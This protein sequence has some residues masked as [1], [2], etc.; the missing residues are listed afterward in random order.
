M[1]VFAHT[2]VSAAKKSVKQRGT[3]E[4]SMMLVVKWPIDDRIL[5]RCSTDI[6]FDPKYGMLFAITYC[7]LLILPSEVGLWSTR[8]TISRSRIHSLLGPTDC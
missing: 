5:E 8:N 7:F 3:D 6:N 4:P 1:D 2:A